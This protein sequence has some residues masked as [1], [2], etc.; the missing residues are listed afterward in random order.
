MNMTKKM[1]AALVA[2]LLLANVAWAQEA[3]PPQK[4]PF[5]LYSDQG[6]HYIPSGFMG[7]TSD[8]VIVGTSK[9]NPGKGAACIQ[10]KY[11][12]KA[13]GGQKWAGVYWQD[14]ANNWGTI[15]GA[16]YNLTGAKKVKFMARGEKGTEVVE[17]KAGGISGEYPDSFKAE[18]APLTL[19]T[20]W[21]EY[22]IDLAGQ[23]LSS[24]IGGFMFVLA[25]DKNADGATFYLDEIRYTAD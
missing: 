4:L 6:D 7:D 11:A 16:G 18:A 13:A 17:F 3:K 22:E 24:V 10:I 20:D 2:G 1:T 19:T 8:I 14:P 23:D 9:N 12:G 15:K 5:Y 25:K 21:K